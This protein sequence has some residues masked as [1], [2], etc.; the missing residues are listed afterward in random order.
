MTNGDG[1]DL[2]P[3]DVLGS[4][5]IDAVLGEGAVGR[6]FRA[7]RSSDG[8][9]VALKVLKATLAVDETFRRRFAHEARAA[10]EVQ[11]RHLVPILEA[12]EDEGRSFLAVAFIDG[13]TLDARL[14]AGP[15]SSEEIVRTAGGIASGLDALHAAGLVHRDIKPA[16]VMLTADGAAMLTDF[17]LA[18][19][20]AYTVLTRP[21]QVVGTLDYLAPE[22][23]KGQAA[24]PATD[25]YAMGCVVYE[26]V[27][28][29]PPFAGKGVLEIGMAHLDEEPSDPLAERPDLPPGLAWAVTQA[30][31]KEPDERPPTAKAYAN[32]LSVAARASR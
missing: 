1:V 31:A 3:G 9:I 20:P 30:L 13:P 27:A 4:Y 12:G 7:T 19:G 29:H 26:C 2:G 6:V 32:M 23:I 25:R 5:R 24:T 16:N 17:G 28:G 21:G 22:L 11:D 18:K 15:M 14:A 8:L 10:Q